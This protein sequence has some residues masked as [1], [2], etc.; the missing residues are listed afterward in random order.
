M[1][2]VGR[3]EQ[4]GAMKFFVTTSNVSSV[5]E[6]VFPNLYIIVILLGS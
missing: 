6:W 1:E 5:L 4:A 3:L 2:K